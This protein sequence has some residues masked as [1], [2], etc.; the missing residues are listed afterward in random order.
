M[1]WKSFF[2]ASKEKV[3]LAIGL[4]VLLNVFF[5]PV[6]QNVCIGIDYRCMIPEYEGPCNASC[7]SKLNFINILQF[8]S[9]NDT[10]NTMDFSYEIVYLGFS[11]LAV[12][13]GFRMLKKK[14]GK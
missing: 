8:K 3:A 1:D 14:G 11:Y 10:I 2:W 13:I 7:K 9:S 6:N 4:F 5:L 12:C